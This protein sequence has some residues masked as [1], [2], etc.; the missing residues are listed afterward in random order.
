MTR[1]A[2]KRSAP[3]SLKRKRS[4]EA[5]NSEPS[6]QVVSDDSDGDEVVSR[7]RRKL[8]R[9]TISQPVEDEDDDDLP[10]APRTPRRARD[11]DDLDIEEDLE[12]LQDSG[13]FFSFSP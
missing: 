5:S 3:T 12:A 13:T 1:S 9:G 11:Q 2:R 7:P 4:E 10:T 6:L 8:R